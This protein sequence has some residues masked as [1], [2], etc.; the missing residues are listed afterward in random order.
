[1]LSSSSATAYFL[2]CLGFNGER[3][4]HAGL[5]EALDRVETTRAARE[6][7]LELPLCHF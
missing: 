6:W 3:K 5:Y 1:M 2:Q 4:D 7:K